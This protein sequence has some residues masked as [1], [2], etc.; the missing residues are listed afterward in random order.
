MPQPQ[1]FYLPTL[2]E[3]ARA[4]AALRQTWSEAEHHRRAGI[5]PRRV[6]LAVL[7]DAVLFPDPAPYH[8]QS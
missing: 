2:D 8:F 7:P 3:I 4:T 1:E 6:E 5:E